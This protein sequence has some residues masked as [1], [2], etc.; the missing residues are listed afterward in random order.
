MGVKDAPSAH[1]ISAYT[2]SAITTAPAAPAAPS[3]AR[4]WLAL[5]A[6]PH[7]LDGLQTMIATVLASASEA[8]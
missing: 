3:S 2:S 6:E 8:M 5:N 1:T 7:G 4:R